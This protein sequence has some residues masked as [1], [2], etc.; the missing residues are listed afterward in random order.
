ML[1]KAKEIETDLF[2]DVDRLEQVAD[3]LGGGAVAAVGGAGR[4]AEGVDAQLERHRSCSLVEGRTDPG[5]TVRVGGAEPVQ[6]REVALIAGGTDGC[7]PS[8]GAGSPPVCSSR[9]G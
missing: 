5:I 4:V 7:W 3:R 9:A 1:T 6:E 8:N 2:G